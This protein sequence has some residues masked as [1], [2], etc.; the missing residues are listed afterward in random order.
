MKY[1]LIWDRGN[2]GWF[3]NRKHE[4]S[5]FIHD[6][7]EFNEEEAKTIEQESNRY[8]LGEHTPIPVRS[9]EPLK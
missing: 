6:A 4:T 9:I 7:L 5:E 1:Y 2:Q 3:V 8:S